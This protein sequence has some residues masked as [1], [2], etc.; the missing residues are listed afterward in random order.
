MPKIPMPLKGIRS[1]ARTAWKQQDSLE[2]EARHL[3]GNLQNRSR[4]KMT[5]EDRKL[6]QQEQ[7][8]N[9]NPLATPRAEPV[10]SPRDRYRQQQSQAR[11]D[12]N[13]GQGATHKDVQSVMKGVPRQPKLDPNNI[14]DSQ[15]L[16][17]QQQ[18]RQRSVA[19][20][21]QKSRADKLADYKAK[22]QAAAGGTGQ[23]NMGNRTLQLTDSGVATVRA[24][25]TLA[26]N[27]SGRGVPSAGA[28]GTSGSGAS[29]GGK[30]GDAASAG[31]R[32]TLKPG[33]RPT[34]NLWEQTTETSKMFGKNVS[35]HV[36][37]EYGG[38]YAK[39][40]GG[41]A[42]K[43]AVWGG[44][45]GGAL[46]AAQGGDFWA[47]AK[48]GAFKGAVG[49][50][51]YRGIKAGTKSNGFGDISHNAQQMWHH[52]QRVSKPVKSIAQV[53]KDAANSP[54]KM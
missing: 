32:I 6:R 16:R 7:R 38:S 14:Y 24:D 21:H 23:F 4:P 53:T 26:N 17:F 36:G 44:G 25:G 33:E 28:G 54:T 47:G 13:F 12:N 40:L 51:G 52:N 10:V 1:A 37:A 2:R 18:D 22:K 9:P 39:F 3:N 30:K 8:V 42:L 50:A 41:A 43:G 20:A 45:V 46:S 34:E 48:E 19:G 5:P 49:M 35:D 15:T 31:G 27:V 11:R 29:T